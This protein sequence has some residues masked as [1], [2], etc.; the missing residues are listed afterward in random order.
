MLSKDL[1]TVL[2]FLTEFLKTSGKLCT[3]P[4]FDSVANQNGN[5][6][7][8]LCGR[9]MTA[10]N[11]LDGLAPSRV[12]CDS[13]LLKRYFMWVCLRSSVFSWGG[14]EKPQAFIKI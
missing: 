14:K 6:D 5:L 13:S 12:Q 3:V 2:A 1:I 7:G 10:R 8:T 9:P 4:A 11:D